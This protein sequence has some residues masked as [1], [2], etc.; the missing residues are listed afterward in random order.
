MTSR[1]APQPI[2]RLI[3]WESTVGCNL[4]CVHCRR[5]EDNAAAEADMSTGQAQELIDQIAQLGRTQQSMPML[6]FSG[7]EPLC[8]PD[9]FELIQA[10]RHKQI[11]IALATNGTLI[12]ASVAAQIKAAGL[13]RVAVSL[14]GVTASV[15]NGMRSQEGAFEAALQG[16]AH[17]RACQVPFQINM[18][19]TRHNA[20]QLDE[21]FILANTLGAAAVHFFMLVPV[22]CG[23]EI[24][25][26]DR[27]TAAEY[28][29]LLT[30]IAEVETTC[31]V[32]I[33]VTCAPHYERIRRTLNRPSRHGTKG[34]LA[35][36]GVLF[37]SHRGQVFP[38]GYLPVECGRIYDTPLER[39]WLHSTD[40]ARMR[41]TEQLKGP[42]G[43]CEYRFVCGGC[44]ARAFA[45]TGDYMQSEPLCE[46][47][48]LPGDHV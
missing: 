10:A 29:Q 23:S 41:D 2:L 6:I 34:C 18:T 36:L 45:A 25:C 3:F 39:I 9:L 5:L 30:H 7:G 13:E 46:Y 33:K 14:D 47:K 35:G 28:E 38:C 32:D 21:M 31:G 27:L 8:R 19:V 44:R 43:I 1:S 37:V 15:H 17:L 11:K 26:S 22:G 20:G 4:S 48:R 16:I 12:D 40:L 42:C 24:P